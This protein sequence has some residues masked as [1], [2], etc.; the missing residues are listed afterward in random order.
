MELCPDKLSY[1][2][3]DISN[4]ISVVNSLK[5]KKYFKTNNLYDCSDICC[6]V[7]SCVNSKGKRKI[8]CCANDVSYIGVYSIGYFGEDISNNTK[9]LG[10]FV[11]EQKPH[12]SNDM[13]CFNGENNFYY[14]NKNVIQPYHTKAIQELYELVVSLQTEVLQLRKEVAWLRTPEPEPEPEPEPPEPEPEPMPE[15]EPEPE[16]EPAPE[17]PE[18]EPEPEPEPPEPEPEEDIDDGEP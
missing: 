12:S 6:D 15:P 16:P 9:E 18:P 17:P 3:E 11:K 13:Y 14:M 8:Y 5:P 4:G 10:E 1:F 7:S 2:I